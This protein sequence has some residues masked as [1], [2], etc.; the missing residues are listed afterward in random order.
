MLGKG[1]A[2]G[3][4]KNFYSMIGKKYL[5]KKHFLMGKKLILTRLE[6]VR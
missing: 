4:D 1:I 6:K 5:N 2:I 3:K